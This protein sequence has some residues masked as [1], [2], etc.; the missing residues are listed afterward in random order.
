MKTALQILL[1]VFDF[2]FLVDALTSKED[3]RR[4][5]SFAAAVVLAVLI[6]ISTTR[7]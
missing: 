4:M 5:H 2:G 3:T 6:I 7:L 1:L